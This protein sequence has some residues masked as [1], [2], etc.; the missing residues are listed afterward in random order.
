MAIWSELLAILTV[1]SFEGGEKL[2]P[3]GA[4]AMV[5]STVSMSVRES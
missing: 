4:D 2:Y 3:P 5:K 1:F